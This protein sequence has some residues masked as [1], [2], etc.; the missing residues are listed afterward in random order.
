VEAAPAPRAF[1][2]DPDIGAYERPPATAVVWGLKW[3]GKTLLNWI[4]VEGASGYDVVK[5]DL[6]LLR[7]TGQFSTSLLSCLE[8]DGTDTQ[9]SDPAIPAPGGG[10]YYLVR[11]I[12]G[13]T[14]DCACPS[15]AGP[16]D[17]GIQA[18]PAAC[19]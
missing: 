18:S 3:S 2:C 19:P 9:A 11:A 6:L 7:A 1:D 8:N 16:R 10:F 5:G 15:Q 4:G 12:P 13:G 14:Y 17:A